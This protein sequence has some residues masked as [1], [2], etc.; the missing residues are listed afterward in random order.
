MIRTALF[1]ASLAAPLGA[2]ELTLPEGAELTAQRNTGPDRYNAPV[3]VFDQGQVPQIAIDGTVR[4]QAWRIPGADLT[5]FE[6]VAPMRAQL[7]ADGFD[8]TLDC[9]S[10]ACGGFDFRFATEVLPGP[11]MYVNIRAYHALTA[12]ATGPDGTPQRVLTVLASTTATA[13]YLQIIEA[14]ALQDSPRPVIKAPTRKPIVSGALAE[15]MLSNGH[16]VLEG[17]IFESGSADLGK[18]PVA[19]LEELARF[20]KARP[21][22]RIALV[23]H[24]DSVGSLSGNIALSKRRAQ[25]VRARLLQEHQL[26]AAQM[27]A[28]GMG[29]LSPIASNLDGAGRET[30]RRVEAVILSAEE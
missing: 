5:P 21:D 13:A 9:A 3:G 11:N 17:L 15:Q 4:R 25:S 23:G 24:T 26:P 2:V 10:A 28:E 27:E 14:G 30:N 22:I 12:L 1:L 18:G 29:Y 6:I 16:V 8:I 7:E 19:A 20:L